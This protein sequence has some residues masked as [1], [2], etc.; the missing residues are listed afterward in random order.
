MKANI[1]PK[2]YPVVVTRLVD[3]NGI[4]QFAAMSP[5]FGP[6]CTVHEA[7]AEKAIEALYETIPN[8]IESLEADNMQVP[9][10]SATGVSSG[11]LNLRLPKSL[12]TEAVAAAKADNCSL[13][14]FIAVAIAK[15]VA[16]NPG[17]R[18]SRKACS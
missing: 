1:N 6:L 8:I 11:T 4:E 5:A 17:K 18:K 13:N 14:Q 2:D 16:Q 15:A 9:E 3:S 7:T 10:P 12:H